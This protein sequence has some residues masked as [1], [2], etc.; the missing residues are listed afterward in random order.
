MDRKVSASVSY[1]KGYYKMKLAVFGCSHSGCGPRDWNETWPYHLYK[2][3]K[4][5]I[6]NFAV[7]GTSTQF[8]YEIFK[9]H[10]DKFD[11]F[12]FQYTSP[13]RFTEYR[14]IT[15]KKGDLPTVMD[16][17]RKY[18][19]F[20]QGTGNYLICNT[21]ANFNKKYK[22]WIKKDK[23]E[24]EKEYKNICKEVDGHEKCLFSFH[25]VR[26]PTNV[27][28]IEIMQNNFPEIIPNPTIHLSNEEN[29]I[30]ANYI[31]EKCNL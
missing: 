17:F 15:K 16:K 26:N 31:K 18:T 19:Y 29:K 13:Y 11:K 6:H 9:K 2:T 25:F 7:G 24:I 30:I 14:E 3:T 22:S 10:I 27:K 8:Q 4:L 20:A 5:E 1:T 23:G 12:I 21:S 28:D